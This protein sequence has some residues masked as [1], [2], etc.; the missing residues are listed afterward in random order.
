MLNLARSQAVR[1][2]QN[3]VSRHPKIEVN[4]AAAKFKFSV[5][6]KVGSDARE[7]EMPN[8]AIGINEE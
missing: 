3:H 6:G 8:L 4:R 2:A 5:F 7:D 1:V